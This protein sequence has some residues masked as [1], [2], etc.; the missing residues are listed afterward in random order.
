MIDLRRDLQ[1]ITDGF[2][3]GEGCLVGSEILLERCCVLSILFEFDK[4][5]AKLLQLGGTNIGNSL[6]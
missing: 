6:G 2:G 1:V 5:R 4:V 3:L